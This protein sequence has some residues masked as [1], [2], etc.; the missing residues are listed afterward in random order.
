MSDQA[1]REARELMRQDELRYLADKP[2]VVKSE[3]RRSGLCW[4]MERE[5]DRWR[6]TVWSEGH[7]GV[8][9]DLGDTEAEALMS[10]RN[11]LRSF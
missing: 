7:A 8:A 2:E 4:A 5:G 9:A 6:A 3:M 10:A 1:I 11:R